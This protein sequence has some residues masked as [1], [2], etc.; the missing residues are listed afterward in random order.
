MNSPKSTTSSILTGR[1]ALVLSMGRTMSDCMRQFKRGR[2]DRPPTAQPEGPTSSWIQH[3]F[4]TS[5]DGCVRSTQTPD[6]LFLPQKILLAVATGSISAAMIYEQKCRDW[7]DF[8]AAIQVLFE[9]SKQ[10]RKGAASV[11]SE[12]MF[13]GLADES[14]GLKTTL[15]RYRTKTFRMERSPERVKSFVES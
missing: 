3:H 8:E 1:V 6:P 4:N 9:N 12:P 13:R 2:D 11:V 7:Q 10:L 15:E 5:S 14:W